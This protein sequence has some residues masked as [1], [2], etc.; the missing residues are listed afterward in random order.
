MHSLAPA[1]PGLPTWHQHPPGP[2]S[3]M[4]IRMAGR[5]SDVLGRQPSQLHPR[6]ASV[7]T[8]TTLMPALA[9]AQPPGRRARRATTTQRVQNADATMNVVNIQTATQAELELLP[10]IGS[11]KAAAIV[12]YRERRPFQRIEHLMRV[13]GIG[14]ATFRRL[15]NMLTIDGPTTLVPP[16]RATENE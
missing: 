1:C 12:A 6:P 9:S 7:V 16:T 14:R 3:S 4:N 13:R 5:Q 8:P 11:S 15:R 10:G 2:R